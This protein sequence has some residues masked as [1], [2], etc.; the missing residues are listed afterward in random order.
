MKFQPDTLAGINNITHVDA[1]GLRVNGIPH[2]ES[3]LIPWVGEV[4][5]WAVGG[6]P[7]PSSVEA[8]TR[9]HFDANR[10]WRFA[11]V[12]TA[13]PVT[14]KSAAGKI[15]VARAA[16]LDNVALWKD[17]GDGTALYTVDLSR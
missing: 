4:R 17:N 11:K 8:L 15:E 2:G 5:P 12:T 3:L 13:G 9:A 10:T 16:G 14:I 1:D 6:N 7:A